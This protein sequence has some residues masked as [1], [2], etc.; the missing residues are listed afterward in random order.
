MFSHT[1]S[2]LFTAAAVIVG[3][4]DTV[5][6]VVVLRVIFYAT[7]LVAAMIANVADAVIV[8]GVFVAAVVLT[9]AGVVA[10]IGAVVVAPPSMLCKNN[11]SVK[12]S[13]FSKAVS[14]S[15]P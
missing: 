4:V 3:T 8:A 13:K 15:L 11:K 9:L 2:D 7:I 10:V 14:P 6:V 5:T 12:Q 1:Y